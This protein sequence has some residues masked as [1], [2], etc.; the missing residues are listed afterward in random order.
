M[1]EA[2]FKAAYEE[3]RN[4]ANH[5]VRHPLV[6]GFLYSDGVEQIAEAGC[7]WL[8]DI[9]ATECPHSLR[10]AGEVNAMVRV[11]VGK[12]HQALIDMT[13]AGDARPVWTRHINVTDMPPGQWLFELADEGHGC[14]LILLTEH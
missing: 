13:V 12:D 8:L 6:R 11:T 14:V 1:D 3:S 10:R 7:Y 5:F 2:K 9:I 4:G